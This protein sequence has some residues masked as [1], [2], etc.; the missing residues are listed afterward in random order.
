MKLFEVAKSQ[1]YV[2]CKNTGRKVFFGTKD[3]CVK[4]IAGFDRA[5]T[6]HVDLRLYDSSGKEHDY[7]IIGMY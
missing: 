3:E 5:T 2:A 4:F 1:Y 6:D 7:K